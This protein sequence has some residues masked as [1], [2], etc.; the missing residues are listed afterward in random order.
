MNSWNHG[1]LESARTLHRHYEV[2]QVPDVHVE[3]RTMM[4]TFP[5]IHWIRNSHR[6]RGFDDLLSQIVV[7]KRHY[8]IRLRRSA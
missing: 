2:P 6:R 1:R 4:R 7:L 3:A 8:A 5:S